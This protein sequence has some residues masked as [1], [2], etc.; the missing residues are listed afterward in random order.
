M[1]QNT[2]IQTYWVDGSFAVVEIARSN[3]VTKRE[4]S[5][6]KKTLKKRQTL[7]INRGIVTLNNKHATSVC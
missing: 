6:V 7:Q 2:D 1:L 3:V 4:I 5:I